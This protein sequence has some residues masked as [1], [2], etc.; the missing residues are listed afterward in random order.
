MIIIKDVTSNY[1]DIYKKLILKGLKEDEDCFRIAPEDEQYEVFPTKDKADSFTIGAFQSDELIGVASFKRDG[2][3]RVKLRHKGILFK[4]YVNSK[5]RRKGIAKQLI[6][7]VIN[8]V[9]LIPNIEQINLTVIPTNQHAK[10]LYEKFGFETFA[11]EEKAVKWQGKYFDEDQMKLML[12]NN[13]SYKS[14]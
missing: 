12:E 9:K 7:E 10:K 2:E 11:S 4:I 13:T 8:R 14:N 5:H 1:L 3:N 6:M